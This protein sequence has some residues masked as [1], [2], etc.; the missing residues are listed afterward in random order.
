MIIYTF[1]IFAYNQFEI[2]ENIKNYLT[3]VPSVF[4]PLYS[5]H[6]KKDF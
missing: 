1:L 5:N 4:L 2:L 6:E 3:S